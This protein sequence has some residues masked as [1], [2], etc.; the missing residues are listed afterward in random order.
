M[1]LN[2]R[3][4]NETTNQIWFHINDLKSVMII[5][6]AVEIRFTCLNKI[7]DFNKDIK[8]INKTNSR[9]VLLTKFVTY[10]NQQ[11]N[12]DIFGHKIYSLINLWH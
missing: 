7:L 3:Q 4:G 5:I 9:F 12:Q 1:S 6:R 2:I 8:P 10:G 11:N